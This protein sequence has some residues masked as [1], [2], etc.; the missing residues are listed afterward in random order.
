MT[1]ET[2]FAVALEKP[3]AT[4]RSAYL[5]SA[6]TDPEQRKRIEGLLAALEK[7][8]GFLEKPAAA[9]SETDFA[10]TRLFPS[11]EAG[12]DDT[13]R[14]HGAD[15]D[16]DTGDALGF[17]SP[18]ERPDSLG[19]IGHYEVLE[20]LGRG[21]FGIV[22][23][24]FDEK[25][26]RVVAVKVL[27]PSIAA[28]SPARKRF[29]R[30]ARAAGA[31]QHENVVR[32]YETGEEPLP[33]LVMEFV[34]GE[35]LQQRLDRT[36]PLDVGETLAIGRQLAEGL[37]AAHA[38]GLV[39]RDIKPSNIL[40]D[41]GPQQ[42]KITDFG[43]ARAAD[44]ASLTRSGVVAGTPM[45]MAPEQAK[46]EHIDHRADLFS[47]GSVIYALL[48]GRPPFRAETTLAVLKR[49]ADD[50]PRPMR[51]VIP[52]TPEWLC[53]IVEKLHAKNPADRF[54]TAKEVADLLA[55]CEKQLQA[56]K[57][58]R[59]VSRIPEGKPVPTVI[60]PA[61]M[62][63]AVA[64]SLVAIIIV[65]IVA[66]II[67][68]SV[69]PEF[70]DKYRNSSKGTLFYCL[71]TL[72]LIA[73]M[74][75]FWSGYFEAR[76]RHAI[77]AAG[78]HPFAHKGVK[79]TS[80]I[81]EAKVA[82]RARN[83]RR[84]VF[85]A[86]G[87]LVLAVGVTLGA[88]TAQKHGWEN[89]YHYLANE[90]VVHIPV[91]DPIEEIII[92]KDGEPVEK[93]GSGL[94]IRSLRPGSYQLQIVTRP[95]FEATSV[96][97]DVR[98]HGS[99]GL[100][101]SNLS[102]GRCSFVLQRGSEV[103][104]SVATD[105]DGFTPLFDGIGL[106]GWKLHPK[107]ESQGQVWAIN[108]GVLSL[109]GPLTHLFSDRGDYTDF[110]LRIEAKCAE[111]S[112]A[113]VGLRAPFTIEDGGPGEGVARAPGTRC[114]GTGLGNNAGNFF[115]G[116]RFTSK[117]A[118]PAVKPGEWFTQEW[119]VKGDMLEIRVNGEFFI[120]T[121]GFP[122]RSGHVVL[123]IPPGQVQFRKIEIKE[124]PR[125]DQFVNG[126]GM[127]FAL[128]PKGK[129]WL[130]GIGGKVGDKEVDFKDDFFIGVHEVTQQE[131][132]QVMGKNPS[133][134][135][136]ENREVNG[137]SVADPLPAEGMTWDECQEFVARLNAKCPEPG[138]RYRLPTE[139]EWEYA[140]RGGPA[141]RKSDH[142]YD[143]YFDKP[144]NA[145]TGRANTE[146]AVGRTSKVGSYPPNP[147]GVYDMHGN[148]WEFCQDDVV[149]NKGEPA[150]VIRGGGWHNSPGACRAG[151]RSTGPL[152]IG[153][154]GIGL[155]LVR[156]RVESAPAPAVAPFDAAK[157]KELQERWATHLGV[158][159]EHTNSIGMKLRLVPP[160]EFTMGS[161]AEE[162][163]AALANMEQ[164][165]RRVD[166]GDKSRIGYIEYL[167]PLV[168]SEGPAHRVKLTE[169]VYL[170]STE[171]THAQFEA[172]VRETK[173]VTSAER[174]PKGGILHGRVTH[175]QSKDFH[176]R[177][178]ARLPRGANH[179]VTQISYEDAMAFCGWL[180]QKEGV[181]YTLPTEAQWEFACRA[182]SQ[183][184]WFSGNNPADLE[185]FAWGEFHIDPDLK[186]F[187]YHEV[188]KKAPNPFG[189]YDMIGNAQEWCRDWYSPTAYS[190]RPETDPLGP[191]APDKEKK[192]VVRG[193]AIFVPYDLRSAIRRRANEN[194]AENGLGFRVAV[195][196]NL[197]PQIPAPAVA[198]FDAAKAKEH[199]EQWARHLGAPVAVEN[200]IG[201]RLRLIP[202]GEFQMGS[203]PKEIEAILAETKDAGKF[204]VNAQGPQ[205]PVRISAP[206]YMGTFEV[207]Q[208]EYQRVMGTNP[209]DFSPMGKSAAKVEGID[210]GTF[211]VENVSWDDAVE[212]C[213]R[214]SELPA[215][216][217]AGRTYRLATEAQWEYACR[218][219]TTG[220]FHTGAALREAD[221]N[222]N[223]ALGRPA[224]VGSYPANAFGLHDMHGNVFE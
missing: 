216:K 23:R 222:Y 4:A 7:A 111:S 38:K 25:L 90:S 199:Q 162:Q 139:A 102:N 46:G 145:L 50:T 76:R 40:I 69:F 53:R 64:V 160:G 183:T 97:F 12:A 104:L 86:A 178:P 218:A 67:V 26:Q 124:L 94:A 155:R 118:G 166:P 55:D 88:W 214:L 205:R 134:F 192:R 152:S 61:E 165:L 127:K 43:L 185:K 10:S 51:E 6:C 112:E 68:L 59:D 142:G 48:T 91:G 184:P 186:E 180:S 41:A 167:R 2:I 190:V 84:R 54:Q 5:D 74:I 179:P 31:V 219:G 213:R 63:F 24:A 137:V 15:D 156:V 197:K 16:E 35:T 133:A 182:G 49:V 157:A 87:L 146:Q 125:A 170:G 106:A 77:L 72:F 203:T 206:Y 116:F 21:G 177:N 52:E 85:V 18:A 8:D 37:A 1:D 66:S 129:G 14:L 132:A 201:M 191:T 169:P 176:W 163:Q 138:W 220:H 140:C 11:A 92:L 175:E 149:D 217:A 110:H 209:S 130:G 45:Y 193:G 29:L 47:L 150:R 189:L 13:T 89:T 194:Y 44:D 95:G 123:R 121:S 100:W 80:R 207:T 164:L 141:E 114:I 196:G 221:A 159:V 108:F 42:V 143:Y 22:F 161:N 211:P 70:F 9:V 71:F 113:T 83:W 93:V 135:K 147:L 174:N 200:S 36:G 105:T 101:T 188:A 126:I 20:M 224:P 215:E 34:P 79:D 154:H 173:Y 117:G 81:P 144:S 171:V 210:T 195:V 27:M 122:F 172:F 128:V 78:T 30:E 75:L 148:V 131:W 187:E 33:Y 82:P 103:R 56:H 28:T 60:A 212:F 62:W 96:T 115:N 17:L 208:A 57:E 19:R 109:N 3:D 120:S 181:T 158:K 136:G 73:F 223:A 153:N 58:V 32:I 107:E 168:A 39:H 202:P 99:T 151:G 98:G 198:P 119:I 65:P 204:L